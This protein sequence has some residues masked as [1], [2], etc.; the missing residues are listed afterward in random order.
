MRELIV[1]HAEVLELGETSQS[2]RKVRCT[3]IV[4]YKRAQ[5]RQ[6]AYYPRKLA[7][8]VVG[9][10]QPFERRAHRESRWQLRQTCRSHIEGAA[11]SKVGGWQSLQHGPNLTPMRF[12]SHKCARYV[13]QGELEPF[14]QCSIPTASQIHRRDV[15]RDQLLDRRKGN[16]HFS[17]S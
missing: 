2:F 7:E 17:R 16:L 14:R 9:D 4:R 13:G 3:D 15:L 12:H 8:R 5:R 11:G 1:R 6:I 10:V